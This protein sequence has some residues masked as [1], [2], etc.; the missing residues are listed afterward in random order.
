M[1]LKQEQKEKISDAISNAISLLENEVEC[2]I[3]DEQRE[4]VDAVIDELA[5][6]QAMLNNQHI[7]KLE[8]VIIQIILLWMVEKVLTYLLFER[9][10]Y[11]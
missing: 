2:V 8:A 11:Q 10:N 6:A 1:E 9:Y 5:T 4:E 3:E 7:Q